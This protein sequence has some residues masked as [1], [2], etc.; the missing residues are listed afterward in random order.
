MANVFVNPEAWGTAPW[1]PN[2]TVTADY[3]TAPDGTLTAD[4]LID[5][6]GGGTGT[7]RTTQTI[8]LD[9]SYNP[10][11]VSCWAK[12]DQLAWLRI[13]LEG[14]S[15]NPTCYF[16]LTTGATGAAASTLSQGT[17]EY[18]DGWWRC[19]IQF[20]TGADAGGAA[21]FGVAEANGDDV[22]DRDGTS[23]ILVWGS[24]LDKDSLLPYTAVSGKVS[25]FLGGLPKRRS[26]VI[27]QLRHH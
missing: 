6:N 22:V 17:V 26:N 4:R 10:Y 7:V 21:R 3:A 15:I 11:Y 16:N 25:P 8:A 9:T 19:W 27:H 14:F 20:E 12:A 1:A 2:Q 18:P 24:H 5:S 13:Y 23:S